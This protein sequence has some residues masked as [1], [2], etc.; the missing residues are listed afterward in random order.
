METAYKEVKSIPEFV[1]AI[2]LR[3]EV[4]IIEQGY[5][6]NLEPD[7][8]D[9]VSRHFI[10]ICDGKVVSTA[11]VLETAAGEF[12]IGR[13]ATKKEFRGRGIGKGLLAHIVETI[14]VLKPKRVW[15]RS[16]THAENFYAK[17]GFKK[18]TEPFD[19]EGTPHVDMELL[20]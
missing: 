12:R 15:L 16:Q 17:C 3:V 8:Q 10:A 14:R 9:R 4:F 20:R 5:P 7:E 6:S 18:T 11:R 1:D 2:R 19:Y 13:M